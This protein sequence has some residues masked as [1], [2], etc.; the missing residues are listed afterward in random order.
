MHIAGRD[1]PVNGKPRIHDYFVGHDC[2]T[3]INPTSCAA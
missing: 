2:G 3:V 1:P